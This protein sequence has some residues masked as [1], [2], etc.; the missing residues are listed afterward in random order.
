MSNGGAFQLL[1]NDGKQDD[2]ILANRFLFSRL[3]QIQNTRAQDPRYSDPTPTLADVEKTHLLFVNAHFKPFVAAAHEYQVTQIGKTGV[4]QHV[5]FSIPLYGDF[6]F[7]MAVHIQLSAITAPQTGPGNQYIRYCEYPGERM[8]QT[9]A[10]SVNGNPLDQ[11]TSDVYPFNREFKVDVNKRAGYNRMMGQQSVITGKAQ[12]QGGRSAGYST[13]VDIYNGPQTP[14][15]TQPALDLW[16]PILL[17]YSMDVRLSLPS[18]AIPF[19]QRFLD[20]NLASTNQLLQYCGYSPFEDAPGSNPITPDVGIA[21]CEL[22]I[23]NI[24]VHPQI[25]DIYVKRIGFNL[26]RVYRFQADTYTAQT[27]NTLMSSFKWPIETIYG[28]ARPLVNTDVT[29]TL[30]LDNWH[31]FGFSTQTTIQTGQLD[32]STWILSAVLAHSPPQA[33]DLDASITHLVNGNAIGTLSPSF[34]GYATSIGGSA[35]TVLSAAQINIVLGRNNLAPLNP[36]ATYVNS[37]APLST[38]IIAAM[39]RGSLARYY[40]NSASLDT[41]QL[42]AHGID[43]FKQFP[44]RFYNSYLPYFYGD[45]IYTPQDQGKFVIFFNFYPGSYQPSGH[46]NISRAREFYFYYTGVN[47]SQVNTLGLFLIAITINFLLI[48]DG[49]AVIRYST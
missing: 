15:V 39:P 18:V 3:N 2:M 6:I 25:H 41:I 49:S 26:I 34:T 33:G 37:L 10:F 8:L 29:Q 28:G 1:T 23:D 46:I 13:G 21:V 17:W 27:G 11:Y 7:D 35:T 42:Q 44:I 19:G 31:I 36:N 16:I 47:I 9:V 24:F 12:V 5:Q 45:H 43:L 4:G 14:M 22:Y 32:A 30:M 40:A 38:E 48:S 20:I